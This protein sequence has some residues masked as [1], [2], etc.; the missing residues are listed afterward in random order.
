MRQEIAKNRSLSKHGLRGAPHLDRPR[1]P[2]ASPGLGPTLHP[3]SL[4]ALVW[5]EM[6]GPPWRSAG[7]S[8]L[9]QLAAVATHPYTHC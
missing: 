7:S 9:S 5:T 6:G 2:Q 3:G 4:R 1:S 8:S